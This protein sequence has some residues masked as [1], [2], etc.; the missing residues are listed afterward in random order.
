M[1]RIIVG[2]GNDCDIVINDSTDKVSRHHLVISV[3]FWGRM[4]VSDTSSNGTYL[5]GNRMLKGTSLPVTR[6]DS[7]RLGDVWEFDWNT[8][9]DPYSKMRKSAAAAAA[10]LLVLCAGI[11]VWSVFNNK[12]DKV[13]T[14]EIPVAAEEEQTEWNR[15]STDKYA[16]VESSIKTAKRATKKKKSR[17]TNVRRK[18]TKRQ[19]LYNEK[20]DVEPEIQKK[21]MSKEKDMPVVN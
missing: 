5:N 8:L 19:E 14:T 13:Q 1:K 12:D 6:K 9:K 4:T 7:I 3:S 11:A 16:P 2:R 21:D 17:K 15:D 10:M 18:K 20:Q